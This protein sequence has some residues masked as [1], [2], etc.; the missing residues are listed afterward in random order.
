MGALMAVLWV[1]DFL[2]FSFA[3]ESIFMNG[4]GGII[5]FASEYAILS[6]G[7]L[8][9]ASKYLISLI[10]IRRASRRGGE[11]APP[12]EEKSMWIFYVE[13][14]TDFWKLVTYLTFFMVVL[15]FY[16]LPLNII[17]DVY[18]TGRAFFVRCRDL[19]RYRTAT[20][21]MDQR[22][23]NATEQEMTAMSDRTCIICR[24]EMVLPSLP[25]PQPQER[26][27]PTVLPPPP[28][29]P[30]Q[31]DGPN[32]TPKKLPCGHIFHFYCLRSWLERQQNCP[33]C[34]RTVLE[35]NPAQAPAQLPPPQPG[36]APQQ[37]GNV[38]G[39]FGRLMGVA[40]AP[41]IV[42]GQFANGALPAN[43]WL[44]QQAPPG[45]LPPPQLAPPRRFNG[46]QAPGGRWQPW[47]VDAE[48]HVQAPPAE[49]GIPPAPVEPAGRPHEQPA[50]D[51]G[52]RSPPVVA[53][54]LPSNP[55]EAAA[56]A[57]LRRS[58][59]T[60]STSAVNS[61]NTSSANLRDSQATAS[62]S[63]NVVSGT[64]SGSSNQ[65]AQTPTPTTT[66]TSVPEAA[67]PSRSNLPTLIPLYDPNIHQ[68]STNRRAFPPENEQMPNGDLGQNPFLRQGGIHQPGFGTIPNGGYHTTP[69]LQP[70]YFSPFPQESGSSSGTRSTSATLP[71]TLT[72][73]QLSRLDRLTRDAIDERLKILERVQRATWSC[74]E[75]LV[76]VRS[77]L[78]HQNQRTGQSNASSAPGP[79]GSASSNGVP[80]SVPSSS[81]K[82]PE[83]P[84]NSS[85][86]QNQNAATQT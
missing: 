72:D 77:V 33:T 37:P 76:R 12:W 82:S 42:P 43:P 81:G 16:G 85:P 50:T 45:V 17:R 73:E 75:D 78:P 63:Q 58:G 20:R 62:A 27:V 60:P 4:V 86:Q 57:A 31:T 30:P 24:E 22:Y 3:I 40:G 19:I 55:R 28:P 5:L 6:A 47:P 32:T 52:A 56:L 48:D 23:P 26:E 71:P 15:T 38:G 46:F 41:P 35:T 2:M 51:Q 83:G 65:P 36:A 39:L 84:S 10:E 80:G 64:L 14:A 66:T 11:N 34:R 18:I 54:A 53:D 59:S 7:L 69:N 70:Q 49:T 25:T 74:I 9:S 79:S 67:G 1:A 13:L 44:Q 21:N 29:P 68:F 61:A 8:N